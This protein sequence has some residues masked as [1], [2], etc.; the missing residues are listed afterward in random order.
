MGLALFEREKHIL[1]IER[2]WIIRMTPEEVR[3]YDREGRLAVLFICW[4]LIYYIFTM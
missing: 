1:S 3:I 2:D 4:N